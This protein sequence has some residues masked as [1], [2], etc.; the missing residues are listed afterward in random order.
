[1]WNVRVQGWRRYSAAGAAR[2][3]PLP[4]FR[5]PSPGHDD[6]VMACRLCIFESSSEKWL[7]SLHPGLLGSINVFIEC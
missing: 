3:M 4:L 7:Y 6:I 2:Y 5:N 1:M